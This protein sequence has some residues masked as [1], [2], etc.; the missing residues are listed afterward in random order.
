MDISKINPPCI[1]QEMSSSPE[2]LYAIGNVNLLE[3]KNLVAIVGSRRAT[4]YG[5]KHAH[6]ISESLANS[7]VVIVSGL[8]LGID[9]A[10]HRGALD[11]SGKTIAVLG[12]AID[13]FTPHT[14]QPL[15]RR[16]IDSGGLILSEY[17]PKSQTFPSNFVFR[18]RI[19]A[20]LSKAT[21]VIEAQEKSGALI[22]ADL[23]IEYNRLVYALPGDVDRANSKG[24]NQLITKGAVCLSDVAVILE[25]LGLA[26]NKQTVLPL[27]DLELKV[28]NSINTNSKNFDKII[29]DTGLKSAELLSILLT[30]E[31]KAQVKKNESGEYCAIIN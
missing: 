13:D 10:A 12:S 21:I 16:I 26:H 28:V 15:A 20:G 2:K 7:G 19:I 31:L 24:T 1:L 30:L 23:A 9:A 3:E 6:A 25:D 5:L 29:Q 4:S 27:N 18:N 11:A 17:P 8:A 14:N 22:T